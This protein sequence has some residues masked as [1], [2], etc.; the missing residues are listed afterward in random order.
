M[1]PIHTMSM[2]EYRD[3]ATLINTVILLIRSRS[4]VISLPL[5]LCLSFSFIS[6]F[7][8]ACLIYFFLSFSL[9]VR[10]FSKCV[11]RHGPASAG[12][13]STTG[14]GGRVVRAPSTT[15]RT[16]PSATTSALAP[17][18]AGRMAPARASG[19]RPT[20]RLRR[21]RQRPRRRSLGTGSV[22]P[23][24]RSHAPAASGA[25]CAR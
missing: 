3:V 5:S 9:E 6:A 23:L 10:S 7:N 14:C 12:S 15:T 25:G 13:S 2:L 21:L 8:Y 18:G 20:R 19:R 16:S 1:Y 17:R 24:T 22:T 4:R 11:G